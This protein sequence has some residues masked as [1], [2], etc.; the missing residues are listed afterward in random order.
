MHCSHAITHAK[1]VSIQFLEL[2]IFIFFKDDEMK[3]TDFVGLT[4]LIVYRK[5][6]GNVL[7][8]WRIPSYSF[9]FF[10]LIP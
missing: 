9:R 2:V 8:T 7:Y 3:K 5:F 1:Q 6:V 10:F 4:R